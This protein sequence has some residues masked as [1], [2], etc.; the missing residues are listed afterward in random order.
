ML[1]TSSMV[2]E[3]YFAIAYLVSLA[4]IVGVAIVRPVEQ[5]AVAGKLKWLAAGLGT[6]LFA[7]VGVTLACGTTLRALFRSLIID[8]AL[9]ARSY[10][11]PLLTYVDATRKGSILLSVVALG[12]AIG[13]FRWRHRGTAWLGLLKVGTGTGLLCAFFISDR[14]ALAGSLPFL[15]LLLVDAQ[16]MSNTMYSNRLLL[17]L[18]CPLF[19][20]QLFPIAGAQ[21]DWAALMPITAAA[22]LLADGTNCIDR[23]TFR[24][25]LP[26]LT[27]ISAGG[28]GNLAGHFVVSVC[29][30]KRNTALPAVARCAARESSRNTL[31]A[32]AADGGGSLDDHRQRTE[33]RLPD[34]AAGSRPVQLLIV[35]RG[36]THRRKANKLLAILMAR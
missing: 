35:E 23:E 24:M 26:R 2:Y 4:A 22:V 1:S 6:C 30:R 12:V 15:W 8:P 17:A 33:T 3:K 7:G 31:V 34:G 25:Q 13:V 27:W 29:R 36:A 28:I 18:L 9:L 20:L 16:P 10:H 32:A 21:V 14:L 5:A 11:I 19:S